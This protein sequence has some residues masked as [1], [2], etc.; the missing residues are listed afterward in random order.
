GDVCG[1]TFTAS[2]WCRLYNEA[3]TGLRRSLQREAESNKGRH[4]VKGIR[5]LPLKRGEELRHARNERQRL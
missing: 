1:G 2:P 3:L 5:W 4:V